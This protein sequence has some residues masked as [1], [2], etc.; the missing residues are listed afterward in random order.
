MSV[1]REIVVRPAL[2]SI[3]LYGAGSNALAG[4][5]HWV[6]LDELAA[7]PGNLGVSADKRKQALLFEFS[8][9]RFRGNKYPGV[10]IAVRDCGWSYW[11]LFAKL[12]FDA[13]F[14]SSNPKFVFWSRADLSCQSNTWGNILEHICSFEK[15]MV[16]SG[17]ANGVLDEIERRRKAGEQILQAC[18][19]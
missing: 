16:P 11:R 2:W 5:W 3:K 9:S 1:P 19:E 14:P 17:W 15:L 10:C 4:K 12:G 18:R 6:D 13:E 7:V 8:D